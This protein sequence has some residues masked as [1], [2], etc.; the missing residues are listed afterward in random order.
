MASDVDPETGLPLEY[1]D[2]VLGGDARRGR[3]TLG[4]SPTADI[5]KLARSG[6]RPIPKG[7]NDT[8]LYAE[9]CRMFG[10][11]LEYDDVLT[12]LRGMPLEQDPADSYGEK[13]YHRI[14]ESAQKYRVSTRLPIRNEDGEA[15]PAG[16]PP[17]WV[18]APAASW[19][20]DHPAPTLGE[21]AD[22]LYLFYRGYL[23]GI[24]GPSETFKTWLALHIIME[25]LRGGGKVAYFDFESTPVVARLKEMGATDELLESFY[26]CQPEDQLPPA[27]DD[28][29]RVIA[30]VVGDS[31]LCVVDGLT[32]AMALESQDINSNSGAAFYENEVLKPMTR[33]GET[34][35]IYLHHTPHIGERALGA[36]HFKSMVTGSSILTDVDS[37]GGTVYLTINK[38]RHGGLVE[39]VQRR[40]S[41]ANLVLERDAGGPLEFRTKLIERTT[42]GAFVP[43]ERV[44]EVVAFVV[45]YM[46]KHGEGASERQ[47]DLG[48]PGKRITTK[49]AIKIALKKGRLVIVKG[50]RFDRYEAVE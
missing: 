49:R 31:T 6:E 41:F 2:E 38:D 23:N 8:A 20:Q 22:G 27:Q 28:R 18:P 19:G 47:I 45:A 39:S 21:V 26:Y 33:G 30:A 5:R 36:Q 14:A 25:E 43:T 24:I 40:K 42:S 35:V 17:S 16:T 32:E 37:N 48:V 15:M 50:T 46:V 11:G 1:L 34:S 12:H 10:L 9:A 13:D 29:R 3:T 7:Q 44:D 4:R